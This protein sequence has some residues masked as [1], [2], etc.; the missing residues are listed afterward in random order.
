MIFHGFVHADGGDMNDSLFR[1][2][3]L[4]FV[5][6]TDTH[7][8]VKYQAFIV[9]FILIVSGLLILLLLNGERIFGHSFWNHLFI[10]ISP[11][12]DETMTDAAI[13]RKAI[14]GMSSSDSSD[15]SNESQE[16]QTGADSQAAQ[17]SKKSACGT[18]CGK[19]IDLKRKINDLAK[20]VDAVN[21]QRENIKQTDEKIKELGKKIEDL[22]KSLSPGGQLKVQI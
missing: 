9:A 12:D 4:Q 18:D 8:I 1:S 20:Y 21:E 3:V 13:F 10:P 16:N 15:T 11:E 19:Y 2:T 17:K 6:D 22:N 14:E 5:N 7:P